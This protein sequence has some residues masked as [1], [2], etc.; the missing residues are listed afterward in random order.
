[1]GLDM[2]TRQKLTEET[3]KRYYLAK[4]KGKGRIIDEF[5]ANTGYNR[6]YAIHILKNSACVKV[7][8][9]N[10]VRRESVQ[11]LRSPPRKKR[12]FMWQHVVG[13]FRMQGRCM[14][15]EL[16]AGMQAGL[17]F[18]L[19]RHYCLKLR[20]GPKGP[21]TSV[22]DGPTWSGSGA[23]CRGLNRRAGGGA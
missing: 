21:R 3:A 10:N 4:K 19:L 15:V 9:F 14:F 11:I 13:G 1:M 5:V 6:K 16:G 18:V 22:G 8:N 20:C 2:K 17:P 23:A 7:T 12:T